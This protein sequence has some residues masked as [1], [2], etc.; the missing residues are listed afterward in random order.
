MCWTWSCTPADRYRP[1]PASHP[2]PPAGSAWQAGKVAAHIAARYGSSTPSR[3]RPARHTTRRHPGPG[4]L[5]RFDR[6][7]SSVARHAAHT[8]RDTPPPTSPHTGMPV[9]APRRSR[10]PA[11]DLPFGALGVGRG[12]DTKPARHHVSPRDQLSLTLGKLRPRDLPRHPFLGG[13]DAGLDGLDRRDARRRRHAEGHPRRERPRA[14]HL[15]DGV[16]GA[17]GAVGITRPGAA[18]RAS[19]RSQAGAG[20]AETTSR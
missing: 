18:T 7:Q 8:L 2:G 11:P 20:P 15:E 5:D 9:P 10:G 14:P 1:P 4:R 6:P 19:M 16:H 12:P 3:T 13:P 17:P